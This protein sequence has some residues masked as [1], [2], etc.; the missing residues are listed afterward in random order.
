MSSVRQQSCARGWTLLANAFTDAPGSS[1]AAVAEFQ[2]SS[3]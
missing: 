2:A 1:G 3:P